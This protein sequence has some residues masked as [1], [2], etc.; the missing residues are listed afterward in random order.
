M[1]RHILLLAY[2]SFLR[3]K[4]TFLI[5]LMGLSTGLA[6]TLFIYLWVNDELHVDKFHAKDERLFRVMERRQNANDIIVSEMTSGPVAQALAEEMPEV[7]FAAAVMHYS[8]F[9]KFTLSIG[10]EDR[11]AFK[12]T[13]QFASP[14]FF[15]VFS[16][17]L[18]QG[19]AKDVLRDKNAIVLS[20]QLAQKLFRTT[21]NVVGKTMV[22]KVGPL[23]KPVIVTGI[24]KNVPT[25]SSEQF[26]FLLSFEAWKDINPGVLEWGNNGTHTYAVLKAGANP[27]QFNNKIANLLARKVGSTN[28]QLLLKPYSQKYL[29]GHYENGVQTGGRIVY[30]KLFSVI[31]LFILLIA[32]INFMNLSTAKASSRTKEIGVKKVMGASRSTLIWQYLSESLLM[33]FVSLGVALLLV[34]LLL[35]A[36][37]QITGKQLTLTPDLSFILAI[38]T[39]TLCTGLIAGS[40]P[41]LYLSGFNPVA[42]LKGK[43]QTVLGEVLIRK[44]LVVFQFALSVILMVAV[45]VVYQQIGY[46][47]TKQLGYDKNNIIYF[48]RQGKLYENQDAFLAAVK[49]TPGV[50]NASSISSS[51]IGSH[52]TTGGLDWEGKDPNESIDFELVSVNYDL[53][54]TLG[55]QMAAGRAFSKNFATDN[56]KIIFNEAAVT[57]MGLKDPVGKHINLW[58]TDREI[59][60]V[61]KNFHFESLHE[62]VKPLFFVLDPPRTN[63]IMVKI[64]A[65]QTKEV[66][67]EVRR[68]HEAFN[69]SF[70]FDYKFLDQDF[71]A[72]YVA[73]QRVAVLSQYFAGFAIL[74]SCL[75][76]FGLAAFTAERRRKEIGVRKVLGASRFS[77]V[78]LLSSDFTKLVVVAIC[79]ALPLSYLV[80]NNWLNNFEF[81]ID[82]EWWYFA[83]AGL[84]ALLVAW[85]TVSSQAIK[86]ASVNPAQSLKDE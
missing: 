74:I 12:G 4:S 85:L 5:N 20:E 37:N 83:G 33:A 35:P 42:V 51:I 57:A 73:E 30:V 29:Y 81:R 3:F 44:G 70:A 34:V 56:T 79:I 82:L 62:N 69:P 24:F 67:S 25:N 8:W 72:L 26:D 84:A 50:V 39:V 6:C 78:Y 31:A 66:I 49:N 17:N 65:G 11:Q 52:N 2:R 48:D 46:I 71:Q 64:G 45:W 32:C 55:I 27:K 76:L 40:Y 21:Q 68:L 22:W 15:Q 14:D 10:E 53:L 28:R 1:F 16:Y 59:V 75:G 77:I 23:Q 41:A 36:F 63:T 7:E 18:I 58:G 13:G 38:L 80:V 60:G 43:L 61:A 9:P 86:A 47:Q 54:Q 19:Q